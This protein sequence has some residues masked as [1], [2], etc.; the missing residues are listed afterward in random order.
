MVQTTFPRDLIQTQRQRTRTYAAL[1]RRPYDTVALRRRLQRLDTRIASHPFWRTPAGRSPAAK[2]ELREWVREIEAV[3]AGLSDQQ[4]RILTC[5]REFT[6]EH[7]GSPSLREIG[8]F[9]GLSSTGSVA[10]QLGQLEQLGVLDRGHGR[11]RG[12]TMCW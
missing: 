6:A 2:V 4:Q 10:Y 3:E 11:N 1:E 9:V 5:I 8:R 12:I 7:G